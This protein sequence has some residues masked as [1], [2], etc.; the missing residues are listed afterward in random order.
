MPGGRVGLGRGPGIASGPFPQA[1][2][3][4]RRAGP[5]VAGLRGLCRWGLGYAVAQGLGTL[6]PR[7]RY[8]VTGTFAVLNSSI[9]SADGLHHR[10]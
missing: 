1:A 5:P 10:P 8:R 3:R 2:R 4:T 7:Y 6:P 9:P